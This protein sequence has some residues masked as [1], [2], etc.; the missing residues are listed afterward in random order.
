MTSIFVPVRVLIYIYILSK[1]F[2]ITRFTESENDP[3]SDPIVVWYQGGQ[4]TIFLEYIAFK[5][6]L[7]VAIMTLITNRTWSLVHVGSFHRNW[8]RI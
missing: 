1:N 5:I 7:S 4:Y 8:V 6:R 3:E 2:S